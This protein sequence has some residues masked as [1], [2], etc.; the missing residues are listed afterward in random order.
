[1]TSIQNQYRKT[2]LN[3]RDLR[4]KEYLGGLCNVCGIDYNLEFDHVDPNSK[5][6]DIST[7]IH[8]YYWSWDR[9]I[10]ELDKCQLLCEEHHIEKSKNE[11]RKGVSHGKYHAAYHLKCDCD[12]C[13]QYKTDYIKQQRIKRDNK[14]REDPPIIHHG[15]RAGYLKEGRLKLSHCEL[16]KQANTEYQRNLRHASVSPCGPNALKG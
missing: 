7:A 4:A 2:Y 12:L 14:P 9:L 5:Q 13:V 6:I 1:M 3:K 15:T 8:R 11:K 16:C 10:V